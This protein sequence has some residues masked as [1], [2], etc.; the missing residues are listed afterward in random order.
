MILTDKAITEI[1]ESAI[2][3]KELIYHLANTSTTLYRWLDK[4]EENG[5]LTT[6]RSV[7]IIKEFGKMKTKD[8]LTKKNTE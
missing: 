6:F 2:L 3:K 4:N 5:T 7:E 8:I 1:K